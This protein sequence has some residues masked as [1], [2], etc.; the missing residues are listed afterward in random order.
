[1]HYAVYNIHIMYVCICVRVCLEFLYTYRIKFG[2][3]IMKSSINFDLLT[4]HFTAKYKCSVGL[5]GCELYIFCM[6]NGILNEK[7]I[8]ETLLLLFFSTDYIQLYK[9]ITQI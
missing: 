1:M 7:K 8:L 6:Y 9:A 3:V 2:F 5:I 4:L